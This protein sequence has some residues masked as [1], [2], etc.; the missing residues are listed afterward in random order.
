MVNC[1]LT[2]SCWDW[3][4]VKAKQIWIPSVQMFAKSLLVTGALTC[5][6]CVCQPAQTCPLLRIPAIDDGPGPASF[7]HSGTGQGTSL[8]STKTGGGQTYACVLSH[9]NQKHEDVDMQCRNMIHNTYEQ[10]Y[11]FTTLTQSISCKKENSSWGASFEGIS[12]PKKPV[13]NFEKFHRQKC[14]QLANLESIYGLI[15]PE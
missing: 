11:P 5:K 10:V 7:G 15:D 2:D 13:V 1:I 8:V 6:Y 4:V 12:N 3:S 14:H 9:V